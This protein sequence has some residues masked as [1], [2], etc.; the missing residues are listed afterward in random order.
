MAELVTLGL[1]V[2]EVTVSTVVGMATPAAEGLLASLLF[3]GG[4][5]GF[6]LTRAV[7]D[8]VGDDGRGGRSIRTVLVG[9]VADTVGEVGVGTQA[10]SLVG[11]SGRAAEA[12]RVAEQ[13]VDAVFLYWV[14]VDEK[15]RRGAEE[16]SKVAEHVCH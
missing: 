13:V 6:Q 8:A 4:A 2:P 10:V 7:R 15:T 16:I 12:S 3:N 14:S 5:C 1:I 9:A 11:G